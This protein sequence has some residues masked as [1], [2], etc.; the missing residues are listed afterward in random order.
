M[1]E[2][3]SIYIPTYNSESTIEEVI[4]SVINQSKKLDQIIIIDDGSTDN[5]KNILKKFDNIE[6]ITNHKNLGIGKSRNIGIKACRN[7]L[8]AS[9]DSDV[10]LETDWLKNILK[11][12]KEKN[13]V[14]CCGNLKEKYLQNIYNQWRSKNYK[15]NWGETDVMNPPFIFTCNTLH[16]KYA[17]EK[18]GG[19]DEKFTYPGGE[20]VD[21]SIRVSKMYDNKNLYSSKSFCL[22]LC[23]DNIETLAH[24]IWRYHSFAYKIKDPSLLKLIKISIKQFN[25]F[26][27]RSFFDLFN[28]KF[29]FIL[30]NFRVFIKF[31]KFEL[32]FLKKKKI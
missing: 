5:T 32:D 11:I 8:V 12:F 2:K 4:N 21:Y 1:N 22:H 23:N 14:Y 25:F 27:K 26:I 15:L 30:I 18:V 13:S 29:K 31:I 3:I 19:F 24:R 10:V 17:W 6:I 7:D 20:D 16:Y 9:I 28:F